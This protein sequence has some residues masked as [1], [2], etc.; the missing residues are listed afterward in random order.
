MVMV[1]L[2]VKMGVYWVVPYGYV[3]EKRESPNTLVHIAPQH[4]R[5]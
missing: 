4:V 5:F 2:I 1:C 3:S